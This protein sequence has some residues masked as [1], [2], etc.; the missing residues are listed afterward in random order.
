MRY[1]V[2]GIILVVLIVGGYLAYTFITTK[3]HS[4]ADTMVYQD[5]GFL[6]TIDYS[7]P[8]KKN[9]LIFG[10]S[11]A[12]PL[13]PYGQ[14]WRTGANEATEIDFNRDVRIDGKEIEAGRYR[15]YTFPGKESW[16]IVLNSELGKWG[17]AEPDYS[18]DVLRVSVPPIEADSV[19]EQF[20][21]LAEPVQSNQLQINLCWDK[22]IVP[23][24][25]EY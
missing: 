12:E 3:N 24:Q 11:A 7:R 25:V 5:G 22:T 9:R 19:C 16:E 23:V 13:V 15:L 14:Y 17:Y 21:I 10:E 6:L 1:I 4:P 8:Y 2:L 20:L 18:L